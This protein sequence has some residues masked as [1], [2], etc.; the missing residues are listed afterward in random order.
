[1]S[2]KTVLY[3]LHKESG[4]T[5]TDFAGWDM[6]LHYGSQIDEHMIVRKDAGM[7]DVSHMTV[8][9]LLG[10]GGRQ[11]LRYMLA[12]DIDKLPAPGKALYTCMLD[13]TGGI[14]DD[15]IVYYRSPDNYRLVFNASTRDKVVD[16][17]QKHISDLSVGIQIRNDLSMIAVQGPRA[18]EKT[19]KVLT[20]EQLDAVST[21]QFFEGVDVGW[22]IARTGY[23]GED[24]V[25]IMLP[26]EQAQSL[27]QDLLAQGVQPCGLGARDTLRLEA[28]MML[29]GQDMDD[30]TTPL[31]TGLEW[32]VAWEPK[33][34]DFIGRT[35]LELLK[36]QGV[37]AK[38]V[39][40]VLEDKAVMRSKQKVITKA[41]DGVITSGGYSPVL[42]CSI[43]FARVPAAT[44]DDCEVVIRKQHFTAKVVKPRFVRYGKSLL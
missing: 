19:M 11:L 17:I 38:R 36:Q 27:W 42:G 40:L 9:D 13:T 14:L 30:K 8:I 43:A 6:P 4:A 32:T 1:M 44:Q 41:G 10:A 3:E 18:L 25:E 33:S 29:Y 39:G 16:W 20:P 22:F 21:M 12:N 7:F 26:H 2:K 23:T 35:A 28:G 15:L 31:E 37:V 34:R 5:F 24:G